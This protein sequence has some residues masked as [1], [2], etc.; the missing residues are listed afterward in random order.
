MI[1]VGNCRK[2]VVGLIEPDVATATAGVGVGVGVGDDDPPLWQA[3]RKT[4]VQNKV[5]RKKAL[6]VICMGP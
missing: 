5:A 6:F 4:G 3:A 2:P 1:V